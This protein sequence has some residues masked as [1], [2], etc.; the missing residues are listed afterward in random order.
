MSVAFE[1]ST[2]KIAKVSVAFE[3]STVTGSTSEFENPINHHKGAYREGGVSES[4]TPAQLGLFYLAGER[5]GSLYS[6]LCPVVAGNRGTEC[7]LLPKR[8]TKKHD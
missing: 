2:V 7:R 3:I 6:E 5:S 8:Q 4:L 1:I